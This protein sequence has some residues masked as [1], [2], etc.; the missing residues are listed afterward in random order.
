MR[1]VVTLV[2]V[3]ALVTATAADAH[4]AKVSTTAT[5]GPLLQPVALS[6]GEALRQS[7]PVVA[8]DPL[9]LSSSPTVTLASTAAAI[10]NTSPIPVTATFS[11]AGDY[12]AHVTVND[13]S[14]PGGGGFQCCWTYGDVKVTVKPR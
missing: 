3:L 10:T 2:S 5:G 11:E 7:A 14:G 4:A 12:V 8:L 9:P 1:A 6:R 13:Y